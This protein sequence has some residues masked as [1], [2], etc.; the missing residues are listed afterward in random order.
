MKI[1]RNC[2]ILLISQLIIYQRLDFPECFA[3]YKYMILRF[4]RLVNSK[5]LVFYKYR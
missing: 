4:L 1:L 3:F 5:C 2:D